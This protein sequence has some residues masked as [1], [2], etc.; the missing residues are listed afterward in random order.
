MWEDQ[1]KQEGSFAQA[2]RAVEGGRASGGQD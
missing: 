1:S 2:A